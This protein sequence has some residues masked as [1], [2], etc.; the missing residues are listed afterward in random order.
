MIGEEFCHMLR[1][2]LS[3]WKAKLYDI[4]GHV[5]TLPALDRQYFSPDINA[6]RVI[7]GEIEKSIRELKVECSVDTNAVSVAGL[8]R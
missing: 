5:Q 2:E 7:I 8:G 1:A 6:L 4:I 3:G